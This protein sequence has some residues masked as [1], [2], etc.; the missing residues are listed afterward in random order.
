VAGLWVGESNGGG[1]AVAFFEITN[2]TGP[3]GNRYRPH[4][5]GA[6]PAFPIAFTLDDD[7]ILRPGAGDGCLDWLRVTAEGNLVLGESGS[8][9]T[10]KAEPKVIT[11]Q[12]LN[13]ADAKSRIAF[14]PWAV[15][16]PIHPSRDDD[17]A[18]TSAGFVAYDKGEHL[19]YFFDT[20]DG[21]GPGAAVDVYAFDLARREIVYEELDAVDHSIKR[22]GIEFFVR[23]DI[24]QD[25]RVDANDVAALLTL[26]A[27]NPDP[28]SGEMYDLTGDRRL[29][30]ADITELV[31]GILGTTLADLHVAAPGL[32]PDL[33][34]V[35]T[36]K[37]V[38]R[39]H[40]PNASR[41]L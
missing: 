40:P 36:V 1:D 26:V 15:A 4:T 3:V 10:P 22:H 14:G 12:V 29:D 7:P 31:E 24:D 13:Y 34:D 30:R 23:G 33:Q 8:T 6:G 5:I 16:G 20:D 11:R 38:G 27:A 2:W 19:V 32:T 17:N 41:G 39:R 25:G 21:S 35:S 28:V 18:V 37:H 9:D